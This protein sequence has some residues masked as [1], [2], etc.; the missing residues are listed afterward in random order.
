VSWQS[1]L[2]VVVLAAVAGGGASSRAATASAGEPAWSP[3]GRRLLYSGPGPSGGS[4]VFV[5]NVDGGGR[6]DLTAGGAERAYG[7]PAWSRD[8]G[9]VAYVA[10]IKAGFEDALFGYTVARADGAG[11]VQV[12]ISPTVGTPSFSPDG[13]YLAFD[14]FESVWVARADGS[15]AH[16]IA[17]G[18]G[19]PIFSPRAERIAFVKNVGSNGAD[20]FT[21]LPTGRA[22]RRLTTT[23]GWDIPL[24]W[25]RGGG[26][27]LFR[28]DRE[29]FAANGDSPFKVNAVYAMRADGTHQHR[30]GYGRESGGADFSPGAGRVVFGGARGGLWVARLDGR[31]LRRLVPGDAYGPRWSPDGR[32][33]AYTASADGTSRIELVHPDG[34]GRHVFAP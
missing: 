20:L 5:S 8:G 7:E 26:Y 18:A 1:A 23:P 2:L 14:G 11:A 19:N 12:A 32:W 16:A 24:A 22:Q 31:G 13:R 17:S 25:S 6:V 10:T 28:T 33:I 4:D 3:D 21:A 9:H 34:T 30:I 27:L 15:G 29:E